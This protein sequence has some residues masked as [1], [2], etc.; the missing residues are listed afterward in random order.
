LN[1]KEFPVLSN[2]IGTITVA[3]FLLSQTALAATRLKI[4]G[5]TTV[6]PVVADAAEHFRDLGWKVLLDTQG[7]SSGGLAALG[8]GLIHLAMS[9]KPISDKDTEKYPKVQFKTHAI[10]F[11]GLALVVSRSVHDAG[12]THLSKQQLRDIYEGRVKNWKALGGPDKPVVFYNKEP[13]R[14]TWEVFAKFLYGSP[15]K[16][17]KV[18]HPEVGANEEARTKVSNHPSAITQLSASWAWGQKNIR[19]LSIGPNKK[20]AVAPTLENIRL[21]RYPIRRPLFVVTNGKPAGPLNEFIAY[22]LSKPGQKLVQKHG[23]LPIQEEH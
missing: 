6:N 5:S 13:G 19:P 12:V 1:P 15:N 18:F 10:G 8:E 3:F 22:L 16:A 23:Y 14:G 4:Q 9:S 11:D 2:A 7:G 21:G 17:P 20:Q